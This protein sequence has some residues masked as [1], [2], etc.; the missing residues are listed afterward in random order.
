MKDVY[1]IARKELSAE[2]MRGWIHF[3]YGVFESAFERLGQDEILSI[4]DQKDVV[5]STLLK[6]IQQELDA[7]KVKEEA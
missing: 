6:G 5:E 1:E 3:A 2:E 7:R 4:K